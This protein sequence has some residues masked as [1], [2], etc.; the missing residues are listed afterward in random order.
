[1]LGGYPLAVG[2]LERRVRPTG[3]GSV[4][5]EEQCRLGG[6]VVR[7]IVV[8]IGGRLVRRDRAVLH[9]GRHRH[10]TSC[11]C[12]CAIA[13]TNA[14][15]A[16]ASRGARGAVDRV[17]Q[18]S[19]RRWGQWYVRAVGCRLDADGVMMPHHRSPT[20]PPASPI[21]R[22]NPGAV[23]AAIVV[24][25]RQCNGRTTAHLYRFRFLVNAHSTSAHRF[26]VVAE[27]SITYRKRL[28]KHT[29]LYINTNIFV[30]SNS[31]SFFWNTLSVIS[32]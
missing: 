5:R 12:T 20:R 14:V 28:I 11:C 16:A 32:I 30:L 23:V 25:L 18:S 24:L 27:S 13:G 1:M 10:R 4:E 29:L 22:R 3:G 9:R 2:L 21:G 31:A 17:S 8:I 7:V 6:V 15:V 19:G 26:N